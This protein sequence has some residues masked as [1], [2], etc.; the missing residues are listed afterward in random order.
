MTGRVTGGRAVRRTP[1][2]GL[3]APAAGGCRGGVRGGPCRAAAGRD[4]AGR[5]GQQPFVRGWGARG[6]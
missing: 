5:G 4:R 3:G 6:P 1:H 2:T